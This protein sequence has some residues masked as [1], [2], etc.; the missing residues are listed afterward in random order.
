[1][2]MSPPRT[3]TQIATC[4]LGVLTTGTPCGGFRLFSTTMMLSTGFFLT[5]H[6]HADA[7]IKAPRGCKLISV[8]TTAP[9]AHKHTTN[10]NALQPAHA[11]A[12]LSSAAEHGVAEAVFFGRLTAL[13]WVQ[14]VATFS[15]TLDCVPQPAVHSHHFDRSTEYCLSARRWWKILR[16]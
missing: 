14:G 12:P 5:R 7:V 15:D 8:R 2:R 4:S 11:A 1:M 3:A 10:C 16:Q 13:L 9:R 6:V